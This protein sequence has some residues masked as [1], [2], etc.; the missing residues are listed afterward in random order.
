MTFNELIGRYLFSS[1]FMHQQT[2]DYTTHNSYTT[3]WYSAV[4]HEDLAVDISTDDTKLMSTTPGCAVR[5]SAFSVSSWPADSLNT[6]TI[7]YPVVQF[8]SCYSSKH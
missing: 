8:T 2:S 1:K 4:K 5:C 3:C 6:S 7:N